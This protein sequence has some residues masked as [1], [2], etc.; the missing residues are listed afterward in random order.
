MKSAGAAVHEDRDDDHDEDDE[1][2]ESAEKRDA[3]P[4]NL[5]LKAEGKPDDKAKAPEPQQ[6]PS[7]AEHTTV[8]SNDT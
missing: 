2:E 4:R 1:K 3:P 6:V 7:S 5:Q 8:F